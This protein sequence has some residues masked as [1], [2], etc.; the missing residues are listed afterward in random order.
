MNRAQRIDEWFGRL[1]IDRE[2]VEFM[3]NE[4]DAAKAAAA[5]MARH[6]LAAKHGSPNLKYWLDRHYDGKVF[7]E[8]RKDVLSGATAVSEYP[9]IISEYSMMFAEP[10]HDIRRV[11]VTTNLKK[12]TDVTLV[13]PDEPRLVL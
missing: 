1:W 4:Y 13:G 11:R 12:T 5:G 7:R 8:A 2:V 10:P 3:E 9:P 6:E